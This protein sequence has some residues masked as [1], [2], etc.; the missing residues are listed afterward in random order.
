MTI[1]YFRDSAG[2]VPLVV[3][4]LWFGK[5]GHRL[6]HSKHEVA[7]SCQ[8]SAPAQEGLPLSLFLNLT[9]AFVIRPVLQPPL[10]PEPCSF[11][12]LH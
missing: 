5:S 6:T 12:L 10:K 3:W 2:E 11:P 8:N 7:A 4:K 1:E 9:T